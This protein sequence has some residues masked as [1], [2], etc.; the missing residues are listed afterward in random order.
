M[1][2][3]P[4]RLLAVGSISPTHAAVCVNGEHGEGIYGKCQG[5]SYATPGKA[6]RQAMALAQSLTGR[7]D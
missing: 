6:G 3:Q 2:N 4:R 5:Y 1:N 7:T